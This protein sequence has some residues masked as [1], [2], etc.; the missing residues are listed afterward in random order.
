MQSL[1][2]SHCICSRGWLS[3]GAPAAHEVI[4]QSLR[5]M[6]HCSRIFGDIVAG[7]LSCQCSKRTYGGCYPDPGFLDLFYDIIGLW[8]VIEHV[9]QAVNA[10]IDS[11]AGSPMI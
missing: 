7:E 5:E 3:L 8:N 4:V 10:G 11:Q 9:N 2:D 1:G 6:F